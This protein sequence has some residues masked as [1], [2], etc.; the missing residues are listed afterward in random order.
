M[1]DWWPDWSGEIAAVVASGPSLKSEKLELLRGRVK[2]IAIKQTVDRCP[3]ADVVYGCDDA[4]WMHRQGLPEFKR[5]KIAWG[6]KACA[7]FPDLRKITIE[8][9][10]KGTSRDS[11]DYSDAILSETKGVIGG[12]GN[13]GFQGLNLA[14]Q[15][16]ARRVLLIGFDMHDRGGVHWYGRNNW[17]K[18]NNPDE[19]NFVKWRAA[20]N[21]AAPTLAALGVEVVNTSFASDLKCFPRRSIEQALNSWGADAVDMD[22]LRSA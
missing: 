6:A 7:R 22:R 3:F 15:F 16:G 10:A 9:K 8:E 5:L 12:G 21:A 20:F 17:T 14:V 1:Q 11:P 18:A 2:V 13:S 4:W 19:S